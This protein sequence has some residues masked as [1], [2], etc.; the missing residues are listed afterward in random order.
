M[1]LIGMLDSPYVRRVAISAALMDLA[2][3]HR[4]VSVFRDFEAFKIVNPM[5]KAPTLLCDDGEIL[6]DSTLILD[7]L[8]SMVAPAH[9]LM[10]SAVWVRRRVL[11]I[12]GVALVAA[13]KTVQYIYEV[14][15][16]PEDKQFED[17]VVR[18]TSQLSHAWDLLEPMAA[19]AHP[20]LM[21]QRMTQADV[22]LAVAWRFNQFSVPG[23]TDPQR[24]PALAAF[25]ARAEQLPA[26]IAYPVDRE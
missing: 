22:T 19:N 20:W 1:Q 13:E 12:I 4:S 18:I 14:K 15:L 26:F 7:Y 16:R 25:S 21:G 2:F 6:I 5:V 3:E 17:W 10:P 11:H 23:L 24:Y 8:E 9:R